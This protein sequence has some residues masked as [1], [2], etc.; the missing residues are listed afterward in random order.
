[1]VTGPEAR[2]LA[3]LATFPSNLESAWDVPRDLCLPG[4]SEYLG[5]VRSALHAP[6]NELLSKKLVVDRKAHVIGGGSRKRKV[7][8]ITDL[9]RTECE[10]VVVPKRKKA[11]ELLGNPPP[12]TMLQGRDSLIESLKNKNKLILT[13]LPGIGKTSLL[14]SIS[15]ILVKE[16]KT[17][18][19]ATMESFKDIS[20]I[21]TEWGLEYSSESAALQSTKNEVLILDELQEVSLRHIGRL[22]SFAQKSEN[23]I[24]AS[25]GPIPISEGF[26]IADIPPL[27]IEDAICLLPPHVEDKELI[28]ERLGGHP[29][30]LQ[31]HDEKSELPEAGSDLQEWVKEVVLGDLGDE[32]KALDELSLL[33]V[34]VPTDH[35]QHEEYLLELDDHALLRWM[36]SGVEL[37]HLVRNVRSTMLSEKDHALAAKYWS[38]R[39]GDLA[40]LVEM[41][42]I[43]KSGGN[44]ESHLLSNAEALMVRSSAGLATLIGDAIYRS[45]TKSLHRI[46]ALVAIER[47]ESEIASVHLENCEAPDLEYSLSLLEGKNEEIDMS[48][49]DAKLILSEAARRM[50]DRLPGKKPDSGILD[51]LNMIDLSEIEDEMKKVVLVAMAHIRHAWYIA[52]SKWSAAKEIREDLESISHADD[53]QLQALNIRAEIAQ[54]PPNSPNFERLIDLVFAKSGLRSTMLQIT[55]VQSCEGDRAKNLLN[56]IEIPSADAQNN[57]SSARRIA[58]MIWFLRAT[59]NTHNQF[60]SM[61][62]SVALWKRSLCPI[63]AKNA[64]EMMHKLL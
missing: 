43:L 46:A 63:A 11:G 18:R 14:R 24:M 39:Q 51:L 32:I 25:R 3:R 34:P 21:F 41:H 59:H 48:K 29:L 64:A 62:E 6:L 56:R 57:L 58:A 2:I 61:A 30:A 28:A 44:I 5:V 52:N 9:G 45:P 27:D 4:L 1:M 36:E 50:D 60:S 22:E 26:E 49:S 33:P 53:P 47:G 17:V 7:Y 19:F 15:D 40:R 16:G 37:H 54:T 13:G 38:Q 55:L 23:L 35:L 12:K 8:H 10:G 20:E 42:H 31:L